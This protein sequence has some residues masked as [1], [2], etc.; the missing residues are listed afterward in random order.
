MQTLGRAARA[1]SEKRDYSVRAPKFGND[2][3][4]TL[5]DAFNHM[6]DQLTADIAERNAA[7]VRL[8]Q[9]LSRLDL[10]HRITRAVGERQDLRSIFQVVIRHLEE[11]VPIDFGCICLYDPDEEM[12]TVTSVGALSRETALELALTE[13]ARVPVDRNGLSR[14]VRGELVYEPDIAASPFPFPS[15]SGAGRLACPGLRA[16][17]RGEPS[18]R[19]PG[20]CAP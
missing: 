19:R 16:V 3:L 2:E 9:Q 18:I 11:Q 6:L 14:C 7:G 17:A 8:Q 15:H 13:K 12:L 20:R 10:L 4:G 1:V 5:T